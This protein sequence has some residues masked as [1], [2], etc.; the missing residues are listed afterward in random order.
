MNNLLLQINNATSERG[1]GSGNIHQDVLLISLLIVVLTVLI[2]A[3]VLNKAF[4]TIVHVMMPEIEAAAKAATKAKQKEK[5]AHLKQWWNNVMGLRPLSEEEDLVIDHAYDDIRELDNPT[6]AW[7]M[8]LFYATMVFGVVYLSVYHVFG[9][10]MNQNDEYKKE[11]RVAE[12]ERKAYL[13]S[14]VDN[15]DENSVEVDKSPEVIAEGKA[16]F[17]QNC[18]AC[19]GAVGEGGIGPNL[20]DNYWLHGASIKDVFKTI[21]RGVPDKGMIAWEQQLSPSKIAQV[22]NYILS[23]QGTN[24]PNAKAPQGNLNEQ[25]QSA[26]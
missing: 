4:K 26:N 12:Q 2:A 10:G 22:A 19:H 8:G 17:D 11:M 25:H 20:T 7:F 9:W 23:L 15:V 6:P 3:I 24:P 18:I 5:R 1:W 16:I 21:K 14:Q 13:A